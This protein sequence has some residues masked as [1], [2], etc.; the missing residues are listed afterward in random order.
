[1]L[2]EL[3]M[4][5]D[6]NLIDTVARQPRAQPY[7]L[8]HK[9]LRAE[10]TAALLG[11]GRCDPHDQAAVLSVLAQVD[12]LLHLAD[13]HL[14]HE[15]THMHPPL[16]ERRAA[17]VQPFD[18]EHAAQRQ[19]A[20]RVRE[21]LEA[22]RA[23]GPAGIEAAKY[24]LYLEVSVWVAHHLVHMAEEETVLTAQFWAHFSDDE[25]RAIEQDLV[26]SIPPQEMLPLM[27]A[28]LRAVD[29]AERCAWLRPM[30]AAMPPEAFAAVL[31]QA[32]QGLD[33]ADWHKL[34]RALE[35]TPVP[36]TVAA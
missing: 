30:A 14:Q 17:A 36:G 8:I 25:I 16:R 19:A 33:S 18:D 3:F 21:A 12:D 6:A 11:L 29:H 35:L 13:A 1:L 9:T 23:A 26:A 22:A 24:R 4:P 27:G 32:R 10:M 28:M 2:Q 31:E 15:N 7:R 5:I 34:V 20:R